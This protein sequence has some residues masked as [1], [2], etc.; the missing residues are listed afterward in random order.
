[1]A[2]YVSGQASGGRWVVPLA[3]AFLLPPA[4]LAAQHP[5]HWRLTLEGGPQSPLSADLVLATQHSTATIL[6]ESPDT[7]RI[8]LRLSSDSGRFQAVNPGAGLALQFEIA[9]PDLAGGLVLGTH[10]YQVHGIALREDEEYYPSFPVFQLRQLVIGTDSARFRIPGRWIAAIRASQLRSP[11]ASYEELARRAGLPPLP[12]DSVRLFALYRAMG[13]FRRAELLEAS[14]RTLDAIRSSITVD[15]TRIRFDYLF[16][17]AGAWLVDIHDV[18]LARARRAFPALT[19]ESAR[20]ALSR[21]GLI[22]TETP[23]DLEDIP[24]AIY[25]LA[26]LRSHDSLTYE[27][28][29][30]DL[31]VADPASAGAVVALLQG[32]ESANDWY[33]A[34][35]RFLFERPLLDSGKGPVSLAQTV[36]AAW[37]GAASFPSIRVHRFGYPEGAVRVA[38]DS[39]VLARIAQPLNAPAREWLARHGTASLVEVLH[40]LPN[41]ADGT[42]LLDLP[43]RSYRLA[44]VAE[45]AR[46]S[47]SGFLE[48]HDLVLLD[49]SYQPLLAL[50]TLVHEWQH[51]LHDHR[52]RGGMLAARRVGE[53]VRLTPLDPYLA[54][55]LAEWWSQRIMEP[56]IERFPLLGLGEAEKRLSLPDDDPHVLGYRMVAA[57]AQ[58]LGSD[59]E[60]VAV[61]LRHADSPS[62]VLQDRRVVGAWGGQRGPDHTIPRRGSISIVPETIFRVIDREPEVVETRIK[63][64]S[65]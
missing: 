5:T 33:L 18:A 47:F 23:P 53:Q 48:P 9:G 27:A 6:L 44:S 57:L 43:E 56:W 42:T 11:R 28:R 4:A 55:G 12:A 7:A 60:T 16:R 49:P 34:A 61:L 1:M 51:L 21:V 15:S 13:L 30:R 17:P 65:P 8:P 32:Y 14:A 46:E 24:L 45:L 50:G 31:R 36:R 29:L 35:V 2:G 59:S 26:T 52:R 40:R 38:T 63:V 58:A 25:Q 64:P 10:R 39:A 62:Q 41:P 20:T 22:P 3:L 19:W 37:G 54:E